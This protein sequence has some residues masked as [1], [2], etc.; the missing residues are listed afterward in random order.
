VGLVAPAPDAAL[1]RSPQ[2]AGALPAPPPLAAAALEARR[3]PC[4]SLLARA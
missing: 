3:G 4:S 1:T 2:L